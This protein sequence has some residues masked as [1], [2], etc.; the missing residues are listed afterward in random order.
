MACFKG[1]VNAVG[2]ANGQD[3]RGVFQECTVLWTAGCWLGRKFHGVNASSTADLGILQFSL[4]LYDDVW[5][6]VIDEY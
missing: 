2:A 5:L 1:V 3:S 4:I 6:G